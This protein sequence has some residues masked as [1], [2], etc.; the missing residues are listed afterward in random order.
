MIF[1]F[2]LL[3]LFV[4]FYHKSPLHATMGNLKQAAESLSDD[5][6]LPAFFPYIILNLPG[7]LPF[8]LRLTVSPAVPAAA[9]I[10]VP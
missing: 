8:L 3:F 5:F 6:Q 1:F 7:Y 2:N 4:S 10:S 9:K